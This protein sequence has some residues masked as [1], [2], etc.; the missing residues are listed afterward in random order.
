VSEVENCPHCGGV[1]PKQM[2]RC[3]ATGRA[4]G[5]DTRLVG[6]IIDKRYRILRLLGEGSLGPVYKAEH[7]TVGRFVALRILPVRLLKSP[8]ILERFLSEARLVSS[9]N[10]G[11]IQSLMDAGVSS[12]G[13]GYVAYNYVRGRS[14]AAYLA[15]HAPIPLKR[16]ATMTCHVLEAVSAIHQSGF[17]HRAL[18]PE[19]ILLQINALSERPSVVL[20]NLGASVLEEQS[21]VMDQQGSRSNFPKVYVPSAFVPPERWRGEPADSREDIFAAGA[22]L[23]ACLS[24]AGVPQLGEELLASGVPPPI[25]AIIA[26]ATHASA[27]ARY[28]SAEEMAICL[29]P[30]AELDEE[31]ATSATKTH[32]A[33]FRI[34]NRRERALLR[35]P[36]RVRW[37]TERDTGS[38][39]VEQ[40]LAV[41]IVNAVR[42]VAPQAWP[43]IVRRIPELN[44]L[45][46]FFS[47]PLILVAAALEEVD[48]IAGTND[49]LFCVVVGE[50]AM[51]QELMRRASM[52]DTKVTPEFFFDQMAAQWA[53]R[54]G[55]GSVKV[56]QIGR[57]YGRLEIRNQ[58]DPILA[59]CACL[60]GIF[61]GALSGLG[62]RHV[63]INKTSC[64]AVGD[65]ACVYSATW[66]L[67]SS[68]V[69]G[70]LSIGI[71]MLGL[72]GEHY[73]KS[74]VQAT[75][76]HESSSIEYGF[77][78]KSLIGS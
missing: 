5:G 13:V 26:K 67:L 32:I 57:G 71:W 38:V 27:T 31:E 37:A 50:V 51:T 54:L 74:D 72:V 22:I 14:M 47:V 7:L 77:L 29:A 33:D 44:Q 3:P 59:I 64:Q 41:S 23:A 62:A 69:G 53:Y 45:N 68:Y 55:E 25:E 63:E 35:A 4:L 39:K 18:S 65:P 56:S 36:S 9:I 24:K 43:E 15:T 46:T 17:V 8:E 16:A 11:R 10:H 19:S 60:T 70:W 78:N 61:S 28:Q 20:T 21:V 40:P 58:R 42:S 75:K 1:H 2:M 49:R 30:Y 73:W 66:T 76:I 34:L 6:Q 12:E 48:E 52:A